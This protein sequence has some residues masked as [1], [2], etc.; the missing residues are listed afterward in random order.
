MAQKA[1]GSESHTVEALETVEPFWTLL[2]YPDTFGLS[3]D[4]LK[5]YPQGIGMS[6]V[7]LLCSLF[8][9]AWS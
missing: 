1:Q 3:S 8:R 5:S 7:S 6:R 4:H 9:Q 2:P